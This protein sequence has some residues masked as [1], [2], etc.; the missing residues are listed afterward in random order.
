V[1]RSIDASVDDHTTPARQHNLYPACRKPDRVR[2]APSPRR[3]GAP[4]RDGLIATNDNRK[5]RVRIADQLA[6][7]AIKGSRVG[8]SRTEFEFPIP[9]SDAEE[10][11]RTMCDGHVLAKTR[12]FVTY[13]NVNWMVDIYEGILQ[14]VILAEIEVATKDQA[15]VISPW[16]GQEVTGDPS[17]RKINMFAARM[18]A[19]ESA[20][21]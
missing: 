12:V 13:D 9:L 6:T 1:R 19:N 11:M 18:L 3:Q 2:M 14:G 15:I 21:S 4:V 8:I 17:Y 16:I 5:V 10:I 20:Q 7:I